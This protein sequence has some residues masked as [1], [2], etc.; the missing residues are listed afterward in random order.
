M[1]N[2]RA[3]LIEDHLTVRPY[4][5]EV[6]RL[7]GYDVTDSPH[8]PRP[9]EELATEGWD[10]IMLDSGALPIV[11]ALRAANHEGK[12]VVATGA[13]LSAEESR[14]IEEHDAILLRKPFSLA[15]V[16]GAVDAPESV[17]ASR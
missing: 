13:D 6:L 9:A 7:A 2:R 10:L 1:D 11:Q 3:L 8:V 17:G 16:L 15:D 12:I 5:I 14:S 4:M